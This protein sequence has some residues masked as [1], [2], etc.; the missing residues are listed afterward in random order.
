MTRR[1]QKCNPKDLV[2]PELRES[3]VPCCN[4]CS[5][6][7][8]FTLLAHDEH[9][10]DLSDL[11]GKHSQRMT[12]CCP[13]CGWIFKPGRLSAHQLKVLYA[14]Q[15]GDATVNLSTRGA[16]IIRSESVKKFI[17][18]AAGRSFCEASVLD[19]GGGAGQASFA[20]AEAGCLVKILD[21][22]GCTPLHPAMQTVNSS[23]DEFVAADQ[24]DVVIM[25]HV[26][27]HTW[28][29]LQWLQMAERL[30][31]PDG[32]LFVEVPFEMYTPFAK[33]KLGDHCHVG[34][35]GIGTLA[36]FLGCAGLQP[37]AL[38]RSLTTYDCRRIMA[39][40]AVCK[41]RAQFKGGSGS[42][43]RRRSLFS[44]LTEMMHPHQ[45]MMAF[46]RR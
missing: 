29:P 4:L 31:T 12:V 26:L 24:Y 18:Q 23:F 9:G 1:F 6:A 38:L 42:G 40:R 28:T 34:Y 27:E 36:D 19:I 21:L 7:G 8:A 17:E 20:F 37:L 44:A 3:V 13:K 15:G 2:E 41:R 45:L 25:S 16:L 22:G 14:S 32:V 43:W 39:L 46:L 33:G 35:F 11:V 5:Y 30:L 10:N